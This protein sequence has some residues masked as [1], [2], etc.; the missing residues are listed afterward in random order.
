MKNLSR[1]TPKKEMIEIMS[2]E[3]SKLYLRETEAAIFQKMWFYTND[4]QVKFYK[5][6]RIKKLL[7]FWRS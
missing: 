6:N 3:Y 7:K 5:K 1:L 2:A 4:F